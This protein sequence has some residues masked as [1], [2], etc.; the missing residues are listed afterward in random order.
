MKRLFLMILLCLA[1]TACGHTHSE[2]V[3]EGGLLEHSYTCED[4][5]EKIAEA[6]ALDAG[7][8]CGVCG[9]TVSDNGD[10]TWNVLAFDEWD[11]IRTDLWCEE[12]G[13]VLSEMRFETEYDDRGNAL[14][15]RTYSDGVLLSE[16]SY[17]QEDGAH[18]ACEEV[19]YSEE[20]RTVTTY[21]RYMQV[22]GAMVYDA[23][24][25]LVSEEH[26][27]YDYDGEGN[28]TGADT[29]VLD[30]EGNQVGQQREEYEYDDN[31]NVLYSATYDGDE[32]KFE[33]RDMVGP[34]GELYTVFIRYYSGGELVGEYSHEYEF[35]SDG[36]LL[37]QWDYV[38]GILA[39][40]G[41]YEAG[42]S[43]YYLAREICYG[44]DGNVTDDYRYDEQGNFIED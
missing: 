6:H 35:S 25:T 12:S 29:T 32:L 26:W 5:G 44:E 21:D 14:H 41:F 20:G 8:F 33:S 15:V 19:I 24:G 28:V 10:G 11:N 23:A 38:D 1:L 31:G 2:P 34:D 18:Y 40:E 9:C 37:R 17:A 36:H 22:T 7:G 43:G 13:T 30:A 4:C 42:E 39:V 16:T 3:W 27:D